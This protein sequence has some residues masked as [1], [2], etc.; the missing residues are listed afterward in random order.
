MVQKKSQ[1]MPLNVI[2]IALLLLIV[3]VVLVSVF[4]ERAGIFSRNTRS[5]EYNGGICME[6]EDCSHKPLD[7][8]CETGVCCSVLG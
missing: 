3:L 7:F 2:I 4:V 1:G 5:C 6:P 8:E